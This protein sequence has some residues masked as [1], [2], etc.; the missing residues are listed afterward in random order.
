M[1]G[2]AEAEE[3]KG[4]WET[5]IVKSG[6]VIS[7]SSSPRDMFGWVLGANKSIRVDELAAFMIDAAMNGREESTI[8]DNEA[9]VNKGEEV[10]AKMKR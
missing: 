2:F 1:L 3:T 7:D 10:L 4:L 6:F 5:L 8:Q 9:M